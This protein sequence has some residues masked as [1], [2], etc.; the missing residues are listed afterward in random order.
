MRVAG[1]LALAV[2][3]VSAVAFSWRGL[4]GEEP[5]TITLVARD[6]TFLLAGT[7]RPANPTVTLRSGERVRLVILNQDPGMKHDLVIGSLGLRTRALAPGESD[8]LRFTVPDRATTLEY[9]CSF[10]AVLMRGALRIERPRS[11][12]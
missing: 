4:R 7:A 5:R 2:A 9:T 11:G 10:H 6:M 3:L 8:E 12:P 1:L